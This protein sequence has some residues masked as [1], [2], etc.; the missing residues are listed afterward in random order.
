MGIDTMTLAQVAQIISGLGVTGVLI[1]IVFAL[2]K[3]GV[4]PRAHVDEMMK[5]SETQTKLLA[6]EIGATIVEGTERAVESGVTK[7]VIAAVKELN[8]G[9]T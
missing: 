9:N 4:V 3:G 6:T 1:L 7:G 8:G 5:H 2:Y